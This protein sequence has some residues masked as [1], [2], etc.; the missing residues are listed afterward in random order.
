MC[1]CVCVFG[2]QTNNYLL[3]ALTAMAAEDRGGYLGIGVDEKG[4]ITEQVPPL[5]RLFGCL[6]ERKPIGAFFSSL[7]LG[8]IVSPAW[9][10]SFAFF[11]LFAGANLNLTSLV[12]ERLVYLA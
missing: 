12:L 8:N 11:G 4:N 10:R 6:R 9:S 2:F 5:G 1:V 3:N 7:S